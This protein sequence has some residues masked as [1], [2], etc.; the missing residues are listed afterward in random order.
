M[1]KNQ[2]TVVGSYNVG[3]FLKGAQIPKVG[4]TLIGDTFWEGGG[5]KGSNQALAAGKLGAKTVFVGCIGNDSYGKF[6]LDLYEKSGVSHEYIRVDNTIHSGISVIFI[7]QY[8]NNSIMVV[9]GAN[10]SLCEEDID[11][12]R[13]DL[14][15]KCYFC[16]DN[17]DHFKELSDLIQDINPAEIT[18]H[19]KDDNLKKW[20]GDIQVAM[21]MELIQLETK[22]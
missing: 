2:I 19:I 13:Q 15:Q 16:N 12:I 3:L 1:K 8:G 10:Y 22:K 11:G 17:H 21:A 9:P 7:D 14:E 4:E 6:A 18:Q 20:C 5:G